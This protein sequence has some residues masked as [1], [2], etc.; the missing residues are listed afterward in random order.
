MSNLPKQ[1]VEFYINPEMTKRYPVNELGSIIVDW[2][3][4][5]VGTKK[6]RTLYIKNITNDRLALRQPHSSDEDEKIIDYPITLPPQQSGKV[7]VEF[8]PNI[9]RIEPLRGGIG[10]EY[11]IG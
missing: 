11:V 2:G 10:F 5:V 1:P 9:N 8:T 6:E 4:C 7:I 3:E